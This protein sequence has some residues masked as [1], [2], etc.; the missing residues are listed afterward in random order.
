MYRQVQRLI[1]Q[2]KGEGHLWSPEV[3]DINDLKAGQLLLSL[4]TLQQLLDRR[5]H[6]ESLPPVSCGIY[7]TTISFALFTYPPLSSSPPSFSLTPPS[8]SPQ[9]FDEQS[10]LERQIDHLTDNINNL[11]EQLSTTRTT[12]DRVKEELCLRDVQLQSSRDVSS[13][14]EIMVLISL[15]VSINTRYIIDSPTHH[16]TLHH[17]PATP[18]FPPHPSPPTRHTTPLTIHPPYQTSHHPTT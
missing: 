11:K 9:L 13:A 12:L 17:P 18:H 7:S 15:E 2:V 14:L 4:T 10:K 6:T 5:F 16:H 1:M 8:P 3:V